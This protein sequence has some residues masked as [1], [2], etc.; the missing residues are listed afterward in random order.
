[1]GV[2]ELVQPLQ[3]VPV[4]PQAGVPQPLLKI[5]GQEPPQPPFWN[6][7]NQLLPPQELLLSPHP[8]KPEKAPPLQAPVPWPL[9]PQPPE[10]QVGRG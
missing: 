7:P 8:N 1:M 2:V 10:P 4:E 3:E 9:L 5:F 6:Q